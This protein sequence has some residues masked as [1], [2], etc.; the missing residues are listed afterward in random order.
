[1]NERS[2]S[3]EQHIEDIHA[4]VDAGACTLAC[5]L[6]GLSRGRLGLRRERLEGQNPRGR[7]CTVDGHNLT[8]HYDRIISVL[9]ALL[10]RRADGAHSVLKLL[11]GVLAAPAEYLCFAVSH[12]VH[13]RAHAIIFI[14]RHEPRLREGEARVHFLRAVAGARQHRQN[15]RSGSQVARSRHGLDATFDECLHDD[16]HGWSHGV[17]C[18]DLLLRLGNH[19]LHG[20]LSSRC[21]GRG[22]R[23]ALAACGREQPN[24]RSVQHRSF[25]KG[26]QHEFIGCADAQVRQQY[27]NEIAQLIGPA[28]RPEQSHHGAMATRG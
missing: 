17:C 10:K 23:A 18:G 28:C 9:L 27:A 1:M 26:R 11:R 14:L 24:A 25:R 16:L 21:G 19:L 5:V 8:V 12:Q 2:R 15:R 22:S 13:L 4:H 6:L 7:L 20:C 3:E